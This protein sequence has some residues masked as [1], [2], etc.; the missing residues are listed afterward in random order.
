MTL[1]TTLWLLSFAAVYSTGDPSVAR[2]WVLVEH[3]GLVLIPTTVFLFS[4]AVTGQ[5][6]EKQAIA[7]FSGAYAMAL[8]GIVVGSDR[9]LTGVHHYFWGYYPTYAPSS[10][11]SWGTSPCSSERASTCTVSRPR[12][13][14]PTPSAAG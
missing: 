13:R 6:Q 8:F 11:C 5:L 10:R 4:A 2:A 7:W 3:F 1:S 14:D 9:L 12:R